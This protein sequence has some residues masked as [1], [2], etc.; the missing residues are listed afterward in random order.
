MEALM[1]TE[2]EA[3]P[4][5]MT[6]DPFGMFGSEQNRL[7]P[8]GE[9]ALKYALELLGNGQ[10]IDHR[11]RADT[12]VQLGDWYLTT[13]SASRATAEYKRA[14]AELAPFG[15]EAL[16]PLRKPRV[17]AYREPS[18]AAKHG[19]AEVDHE[20][21]DVKLA[22]KIGKEGKVVAATPVEP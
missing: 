15:E 12:Y 17:I 16:A 5:P 19:E 8:E 7:N 18:I 4:E 2:T 3:K 11:T 20:I 1:G 6:R 10:P 9:R 22:L 21:V 14:W 13:G